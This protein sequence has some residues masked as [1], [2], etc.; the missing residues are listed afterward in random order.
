MSFQTILALLAGLVVFVLLLI[1]TSVT[2]AIFFF[3]NTS[4][5]ALLYVIG[6]PLV[7]ALL[8][9]RRFK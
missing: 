3:G 2:G 1:V 6:I 8:V 5:W 9:V 7:G 4:L